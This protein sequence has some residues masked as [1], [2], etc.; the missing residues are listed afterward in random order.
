MY[1]VRNGS[2]QQSLEGGDTNVWLFEVIMVTRDESGSRV[3]G[4]LGQ[5]IQNLSMGQLRPGS[6]INFNSNN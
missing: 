4:S 5:P 1:E 6:N 3:H 2:D